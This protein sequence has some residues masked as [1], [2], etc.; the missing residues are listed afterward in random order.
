MSSSEKPQ[1]PLQT[2]L[3]AKIKST[4]LYNDNRNVKFTTLLTP[5]SD[6]KNN[7]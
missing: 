4:K 5:F 2:E 3:N 1:N 6:S 7:L